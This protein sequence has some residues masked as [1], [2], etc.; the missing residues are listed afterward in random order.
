MPRLNFFS[1]DNGDIKKETKG[2]FEEQNLLTYKF[3]KKI[4]NEE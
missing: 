2:E 1:H 4:Q 3:D